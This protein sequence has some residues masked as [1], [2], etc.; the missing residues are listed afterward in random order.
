[1][2]VRAKMVCCQKTPQ[3]YHKSDGSTVEA[4]HLRFHAVYKSPVAG[5]GNACEENRIFG[6][7][8]PSAD[9]QMFVVNPGATSQFE[10]GSEYYVDFTPVP[11]D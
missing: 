4:F 7:A 5:Y 1:M 10:V 3:T 6:D 2:S 8:T 11:T 9:F